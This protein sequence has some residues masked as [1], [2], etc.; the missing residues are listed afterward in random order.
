M[1]DR[2][3]LENPVARR[4][5]MEN[6]VYSPD[7]EANMASSQNNRVLLV[8]SSYSRSYHHRSNSLDPALL[9]K[10]MEPCWHCVLLRKWVV[11]DQAC[12]IYGLH[13]WWSAILNIDRKIHRL[14]SSL[15][16]FFWLIPWLAAQISKENI[17]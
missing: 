9:K 2:T 5:V 11:M 1:E 7:M 15:V 3:E 8:R 16:S 14:Y 10:V 17:L 4:R 13:R 12:C 6:L